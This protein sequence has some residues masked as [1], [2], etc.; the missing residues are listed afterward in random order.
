MVDRVQPTFGIVSNRTVCG[1]VRF[2]VGLGFRAM[3]LI[4][5]VFEVK[6]GCW[7]ND[8]GISPGMGAPSVPTY[9]VLNVRS[10]GPQ[11]LRNPKHK[12]SRPKPQHELALVDVHLL[13]LGPQEA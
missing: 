10:K 9:S 4:Y 6:Q 3:E 2:R 5:K 12:T 11:L 7:K 1:Q 13:N 8:M